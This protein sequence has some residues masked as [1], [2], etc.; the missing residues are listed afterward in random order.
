M[1]FLASDAGA[2]LQKKI[3]RALGPSR[4]DDAIYCVED[5]AARF[6]R[7]RLSVVSVHDPSFVSGIEEHLERLS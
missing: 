7:Q 6:G 5:L 1:V 3:Q 4:L 2:D